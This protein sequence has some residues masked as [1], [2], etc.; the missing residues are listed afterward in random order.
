MDAIQDGVKSISTISITLS[1]RLQKDPATII[2]SKTGEV[3]RLGVR[4]FQKDG[5]KPSSK[6]Y[7]PRKDQQGSIQVSFDGASQDYNNFR[8]LAMNSTND[9]AISLVTQNVYDNLK[10][11]HEYPEI[12]YG[13][14]G[15]N[16]LVDEILH[17][18]FQVGTRC[19]I[20][21]EVIL[22][23]TE[24]M[25]PCGNLCRLGFIANERLELGL[26]FLNPLERKE[27]CQ[28]FIETLELTDGYRGWY[29]RVLRE[30]AVEMGDTL[31]I[32]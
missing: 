32:L 3:I 13:D 19:R 7:T 26:G 5:S 17:G 18:D 29:A 23:I 31:E 2:E 16:I 10:Y 4:S 9:W 20:G 28:C 24:H 27:K 6:K 30:G 15:E 22:E 12:E 11:F 8:T 25:V 21:K 14:L 1:K